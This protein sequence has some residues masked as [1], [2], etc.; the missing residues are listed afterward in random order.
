MEW[1][2]IAHE[3]PAGMREWLGFE[4]HRPASTWTPD[5]GQGLV[6]RYDLALR[7]RIS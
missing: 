1:F 7:A 6:K 2:Q 4:P 3:A 5:S